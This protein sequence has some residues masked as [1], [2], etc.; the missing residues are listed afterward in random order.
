MADR[1]RIQSRGWSY[2]KDS[3]MACPTVWLASSHIELEGFSAYL[4]ARPTVLCQKERFHPQ[5][6][7]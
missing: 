5:T 6:E 3:T 4:R 7:S 2:F 1:T